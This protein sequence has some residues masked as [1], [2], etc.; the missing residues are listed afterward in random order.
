MPT[1]PENRTRGTVIK[2][3]DSRTVRFV[4]YF[5]RS[6]PGRT[7]LM[8][9]LMI[10]SGLAEGVGLLTLLPLLEFALG[11][12][13]AGQSAITET[14]VGALQTVGIPPNLGT[15]LALVVFAMTVKAFF[16]WLANKQVGYTVAQVAT[17]LRLR[18]IQALLRARWSFF[19]RHPTGH[20]ANAISSEAG[21]A[22]NAYQEACRALAGVIQIA[23]Y[24]GAVLFISWEVAVIALVLGPLVL[25]ALKGFVQMSRQA[26]NEQTDMMKHLIR[27]VTELLPGIKPVKAMAREGHFLPFLEEETKDFNRARQTTVLAEQS[28]RAFREPIILLILAA[29]LY[30][31]VTF[32][33]APASAVLVG[34][35]LFYRVMT[36]AGNLQ[37]HYQSVTVNESAFWSLLD[38]V[39]QAEEA[40]EDRSKGR[41]A[42]QI[43][44]SIRLEGVS[45][46]YED[47]EVLRDVS[48]EIPARTLVAIVGPSG[49]GKTTLVDL[50]IGLLR[51]DEGEIFVDDVP[52]SEIDLEDL[53][54]LVGYVPQD[55][56][57]F[58][59]TILQNVTL[60]DPTVDRERVE[61]ALR[62]AGAWD[63]VS[64]FPEGMDHEV[65]ERGSQVSGGQRQRIAIAR[66]LVGRPRLLIMDEAT[67]ALD[68]ETEWQICEGLRDLREEM[69]IIAISHQTAVTHFADR[70]Y[71]VEGRTV[72]AMETPREVADSQVL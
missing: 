5:F 50:V 55:M 4:L 40:V 18:L 43:E 68:P 46:S 71:R 47:E 65:G 59:D 20:F 13:G 54:G 53:R 66:A 37:T 41:P 32:G 3:L 16:L 22:S 28:L 23:V 57:L 62:A 14:V 39:E 15:L 19:V 9:G 10:F 52:V 29:G 24:L 42:P 69:T 48:L 56:L 26:G 34:A 33:T 38:T 60:G 64:S 12:E 8:I 49:A 27:R 63:F 30:G 11:Q 70:A 35:V 72:S 6:Y 21:R 25:L 17:D 36:T 58:H 45:F 61:W 7:G 51:P 31:A 44:D 2:I 1:H 67:T